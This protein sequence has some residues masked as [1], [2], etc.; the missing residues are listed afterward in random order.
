MLLKKFGTGPSFLVSLIDEDIGSDGL[1]K[2]SDAGDTFPFVTSSFA[3][4]GRAAGGT[5][6]VNFDGGGASFTDGV[7][8]NDGFSLLLFALLST[9]AALVEV[10]NPPRQFSSEGCGCT[11][12]G[13]WVFV[14]S[15]EPNVNPVGNM[16]AGILIFASSEA[17][18]K[19]SSSSS[20]SQALNLPEL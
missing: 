16:L 8:E 13:T 10:S 9:D 17:S 2:K 7:K 6:N 4:V 5:P 11:S 1:L 14:A 20:S 18:G 19:S 12:F 3:D 15:A